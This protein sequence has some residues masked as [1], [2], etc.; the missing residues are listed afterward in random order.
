MLR[1][2]RMDIWDKK[3]RSAVMA[4]IRG[5][6]T[7]PELIVRRYL[8][9][10]GY[11]YRKNVRSLPGTPDIVLRPYGVAIFVHGC[12]W[13]GHEV[14]GHVPKSNREFWIRKIERNK[15]RDVHNKEALRRAGWDVVTVWEC[16]LKPAVRRQTLL[17]LE[18][19]LGS[20]WLRR[21]GKRLAPPYALSV[22]GETQSLAAEREADYACVDLT[23]PIKEDN[24]FM[25]A[26][27]S[28]GKD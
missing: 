3:K 13:H 23:K 15:E 7:K 18:A 28:S 11:R 14:D 5:R 8:Y 20:A 4:R 17:E 21:H 27:N 12:F 26:R 22:T 10:R 2:E 6:D 24:D 25:S 1:K 19:C 9:A 16:Q